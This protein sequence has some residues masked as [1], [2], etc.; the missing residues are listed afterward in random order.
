M[1]AAVAIG[2]IALAACRAF[3][4][5]PT[6][7]VV[8][9]SALTFAARAGGTHPP[10]QFLTILQTAQQQGRWSATADSPW[11]GL[12]SSGDSLP[13][14]LGIGVATEL[15]A[16]TYRGNI[17]VRLGDT[18]HAQV[19]PVALTLTTT[20]PLDGRWAGTRDTVNVT[21]AL[22]DTAGRVTGEG[23]L[24]PRHRAVTV[25]GTYA[26][27]SLTLRLISG[28]DTTSVSGSFADDNTVTATL[29]GGGYTAFAIAL[30]RQ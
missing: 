15:P 28:A 25:A 26:Y 6:D 13:F 16:G 14:Y 12:A 20:T 23:T 9:P 1:R 30:N 5:A 29:A 17:T 7:L 27:P 24:E 2:V 18:D 4:D 22:V 3:T 10:L 21:L 19:I 8:S 11:I